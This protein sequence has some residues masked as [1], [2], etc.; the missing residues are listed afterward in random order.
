MGH[1]FNPD[2]RDF[3]KA[4][5][6]HQVDYLLVGG[7]AVI[8]HGY[9]RVTADMDIWVK[10]NADNYNKLN[11]AFHSFGMPVFDMTL[12]N[13]LDTEKWDVFRF[14]RKPV[15]IDIMTRVKGLDFDEAFQKSSLVNI[16]DTEIR[17]IHY[18]HLIIAK[19]KAGRAKD[20]QDLENLE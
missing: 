17:L 10:C 2:F 7:Y 18:E 6:K 15:A 19:K 4:L 16:D 13:F 9:E 5:H 8:I 14:G 11:M 12:N 1:L 20:I 3:L